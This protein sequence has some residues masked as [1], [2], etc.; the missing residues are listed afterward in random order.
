MTTATTATA[1]KT[2]QRRVTLSRT[3]QDCYY[4]EIELPEGV[5][6]EQVDAELV[7]RGEFGKY[8]HD[9]SCYAWDT[10]TMA[11]GAI[12]KSIDESRDDCPELDCGPIV[13]DDNTWD[14][15]KGS[16]EWPGHFRPGRH[17][18]VFNDALITIRRVEDVDLYEDAI[19][20][21]AWRGGKAF[22]SEMRDAG[23]PTEMIRNE[24]ADLVMRVLKA[25]V[26]KEPATGEA[27]GLAGNTFEVEFDEARSR[28]ESN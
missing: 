12:V 2:I 5:T 19:K 13:R 8:A 21:L 14:L 9:R 6:V 23:D 3:E 17:L 11:C 18:N 1:A 4:L 28:A 25:I 22:A 26:V 24:V 20:I 15:V 16:D 27:V 10:G 7:E